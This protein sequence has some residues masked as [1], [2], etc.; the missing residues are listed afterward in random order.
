MLADIFLPKLSTL[1]HFIDVPKG[2]NATVLYSHTLLVMAERKAR[3][4][5]VNIAYTLEVRD[6]QALKAKGGRHKLDY[7][8]PNKH[9]L[10]FLSKNSA[11][12]D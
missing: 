7:L 3:T 5:I 2:C 4:I 8:K 12:L 6:S 1:H 11:R 9:S 10:F